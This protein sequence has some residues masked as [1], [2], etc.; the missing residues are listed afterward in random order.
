MLL[1]GF[2]F[3]L[4]FDTATEIGLL[5]ISGAQAGEGMSIWLIMGDPS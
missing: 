4:G 5:G 3:A 1:L 2:L